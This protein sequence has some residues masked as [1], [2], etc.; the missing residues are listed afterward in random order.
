MTTRQAG[1]VLFVLL[2]LCGATGAGAFG[3]D[4]FEAPALDGVTAAG[5]MG[6][7]DAFRF[8]GGHDWPA[9][10]LTARAP[11]DW[12]GAGALALPVDNPGEAPFTLLLRLDDTAGADGG[13]RSLTGIVTLPPHGHGTVVL[14]LDAGPTGMRGRPAVAAAAQPGDI[15]VTDVRG[16]VDAHHI[17][18]LHIS[19]VRGVAD[20]V[21][22]LGPPTLRERAPGEAPRGPIT[23]RFG[24]ALAGDWPEKVRGESDLRRKR[25]AAEIETGRLAT[26]QSAPADRFGGLPGRTVRATGFFRVEKSGGRW[27]FVT[28]TGRVFFS[29]GVDA[30][31]PHNPTIVAG[32]RALFETLPAP[33]TPLARFFADDPAHGETFDVGAADLART[34][35]VDWRE[36]WDGDVVRR[37]R[38]WGFNT[39]GNWSDTGLARSGLATVDFYDVEGASA[40]ISMEGGRALPDPFDPR[41]PG[42]AD[43]VAGQMTATHRGSPTLLGYFSGNEMPW[44]RDDQPAAGIVAHVLALTS[45][46]DAKR[47]FLAVLRTRYGTPAAWEAAWGLRGSPTWDQAALL[48]TILPQNLTPVA[49]GD[50]AAL[51]RLF[52]ERYFSTVTAAIKRHDP[53]HLYLGTRFAAAPREVIEACA[54][55]C[56][57]L[58]F[59]VYGPSPAS[60]AALWR[61]YDRPVLI[62]EFH[63]GSTDRGSFWPGI[64]DAGAEDR[65][66]PAYAAYLDAAIRDPAIVG[67]H[68]YQ[69]A[70]EPLTGRPYDGENGHIGLVAVTDIPYAGFVE[71]VAAANRRAEKMLV[72]GK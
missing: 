31:T 26:L 17:V 15:P 19:G 68:W 45:A 3:V 60:A 65:R 50:I 69:Y 58:S 53:D 70:D 28:P 42:V 72:G 37:L 36:R 62:G 5:R 6:P 2:S 13:D 7:L 35:G 25:A 32:R 54:R 10:R 41:F 38:A 18:A 21:L 16:A 29:L 24:Q 27:R 11:L 12:S 30:V 43:G 46:S 56:D 4:G 22:A 34:F 23:D 57:V 20:A 47:A 63:F 52:A 39:L 59:N 48:P 67:V 40:M 33:G 49:R 51:Q 44:G 14:P 66:G 8:E 71:A 64:V 61:A 55:Y 9:L 1:L